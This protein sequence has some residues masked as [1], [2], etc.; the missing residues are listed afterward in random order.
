LKEIKDIQDELHILSVLLENQTSVLKQA[1]A[2][3]K[4]PADL[5]ENIARSPIATPKIGQSNEARIVPYSSEKHFHKLFLMVLEQEKRRKGL[6][7][8]AEQA[9]KAVRSNKNVIVM[10]LTSLAQSSSRSETKAS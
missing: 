2:V 6:E 1:T 5:H 4:P 10:K 7:V 3:L 8:Q 9:N